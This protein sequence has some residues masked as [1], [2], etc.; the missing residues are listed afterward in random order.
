M[1]G[2]AANTVLFCTNVGGG[3]FGAGQ[4]AAWRALGL[5]A[6]LHYAVELKDYWRAKSGVLTRLRLRWAMYL[7]Y[8]RQLWHTVRWARRGETFV[9]VTNPFFLPALAA[10]AARHSGAR[11]VH[12][13]Y[14]LYPD[15]LVFGGGWSWQH[16]AARFAAWTTRS[17]IAECAAT[18]YLGQRLRHYAES[19]YGVAAHTA[20]I[21]V[22]TDTTVFHGCEPKPRGR[23]L[24]RCL[25]SGH[26]GKLHDWK[27]LGAALAEGVP[28]DVAVE[29][30]AD[31]PGA[32]AL[33]QHLAAVAAHDPEALEFA[34]TRGDANWRTAMLAADVALVTMRP[35]AEK[36]VMPSK[37]YS[38]MAAGQAILAVCPRE[39]DLADLIA[40]HDCGW[41]VE[42]GDGTGLRRQL[43]TLRDHPEEILR[44][45]RNAWQAAHAHYSMETV[46]K[47]WLELLQSLH[48]R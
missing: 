21:A 7:S 46:G 36:V 28:E 40:A 6:R 8:P 18:V 11:V 29:I 9:A 34:G 38:A 48:A 39:S 37:T 31:G 33:R 32:Q 13:V 35:G 16:P 3:I 43:S 5:D 23:R 47:Q 25:Y 12:L 4:T 45:R 17:A 1:S 42:P 20:V 41:V 44:K 14:D 2:S 26:M 30:A 19:R 22:G 24:I 27:T 15:A 10:R